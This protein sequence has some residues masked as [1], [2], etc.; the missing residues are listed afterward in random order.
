MTYTILSIVFP[1]FAIVGLGFWYGRR[2]APEMDAVNR[3]NLQLFIPALL[4]SV[5]SSK[6][7]DPAAYAML[8]GATAVLIIG[9]G[10]ITWPLARLAGW[11]FR[12]FVPTMMF[13]NSGNMGLPLA[14]FALG[15]AALPAAV[16]L[17]VLSTTMHFTVGTA[18]LQG[19]VDP[20]I[21][22]RLP[23]LLATIVGIGFSQ[24]GIP[25]WGPLA[26]GVGLLGQIA[27][28][29]MLFALGVRMTDVDLAD[30]RIGAAAAVLCPVSGLVFALPL[31]AVLDLPDLQRNLLILFAIL[32]PAVLCYMLAE[33]YGQEPRKV[34]SIVLLGNLFSLVAIPVTLFYVLA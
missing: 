28:P 30:W 18:I 7:F 31:V 17:F 13:K 26:T 33:K 19:R 27:I 1:I 23:M 3:M 12:T 32:P 15:D 10:L 24:L 25:V 9:A 4:F 34:A 11:Q 29:L 8:A 5:L 21:V 20:L 16:V 22:F 6:D 14:V 2:H